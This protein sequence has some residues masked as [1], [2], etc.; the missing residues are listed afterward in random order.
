MELLVLLVFG[1][2]NRKRILAVEGL[3]EIRGIMT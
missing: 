2:G 1:R 3:N